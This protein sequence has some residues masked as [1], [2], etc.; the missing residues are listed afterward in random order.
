[1]QKAEYSASISTDRSSLIIKTLIDGS[2]ESSAKYSAEEVDDLIAMLAKKRAGMSDEVT[3]Q[4][5]PQLCV[6]AIQHP[7]WRTARNGETN[8]KVLGLRHPGFGWLWFQFPPHEAET[9]AKW[10]LIN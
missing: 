7:A 3:T 1:M 5:D 8:E 2:V 10:L 9:I 6:E 4:L